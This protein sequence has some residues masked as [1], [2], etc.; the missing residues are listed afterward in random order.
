M[1]MATRTRRWTRKD[2]VR[3]PHD[4]NR[5]EVL[6]GELFVTPQAEY[7][8]QRIALAFARKLADYCDTNAIG[9]VVG[10][11]AVVWEENELQPDIQVI[12]GL[13][14]SRRGAKWEEL[15]APLLVVEV[16]SDS[17]RRR[18]FGKKREAYAS[19]AIPTYWTVDIEK[20]LVIIWDWR[21]SEPAFA[22]DVLRWT[23][24]AGVPPLEIPLATIFA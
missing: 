4:G 22:T 5:Y 19:L 6:D 8:H 1:H 12:P 11:G 10:P 23:P 18:D 15:P 13:H 3:M 14:E 24:S 17:T 20:R 16:L 7:E 9:V 2:L 21:T